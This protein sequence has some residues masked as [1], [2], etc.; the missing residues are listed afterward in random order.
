MVARS[1][2][3]VSPFTV[4]IHRFWV[5][6]GK[7]VPVPAPS[8][9]GQW[10]SVVPDT[11][12]GLSPSLDDIIQTDPNDPNTVG[13]GDL[14]SDNFIDVH[15][16]E[17][18]AFSGNPARATPAVTSDSRLLLMPYGDGAVPVFDLSQQPRSHFA[19][20]RT[21]NLPGF[22]GGN[23]AVSPN[24]RT[25]A[26]IGRFGGPASLTLTA[27][28]GAHRPLHVPLPPS[29]FKEAPGKPGVAFNDRGSQLAIANENGSVTVVDPATGSILRQFDSPL[30]QFMPSPRILFLGT[31]NNGRLIEGSSEPHEFWSADLR[32]GMLVDTQVHAFGKAFVG[33]FTA[34]ATGTRLVVLT[35]PSGPG[36]ETV[37]VFNAS[38]T[39]W[40]E[41]TS[42]ALPANDQDGTATLSP[43]GAELLVG[44]FAGLAAY[45]TDDG[46]RLWR[47]TSVGSANQWF[48]PDGSLLTESATTG[49]ISVRSPSDGTVQYTLQSLYPTSVV[50][51]FNV[52]SYSLA[53]LNGHV[54]AAAEDPDAGAYVDLVF[55]ADYPTTTADLVHAACAEA[56]RNLTHAEWALYVGPE[57]YELTCPGLPPPD[58]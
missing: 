31:L 45:R 10:G 54:L 7:E 34:D 33:D 51:T 1:P 12:I 8:D 48:G 46:A 3:S 39:G 56:G 41:H 15:A 44:D 26:S 9:P 24:G 29:P 23:F 57:P 25:L 52:P 16:A 4:P 47:D 20:I 42:F 19:P 22:N 6:T 50:S 30:H 18:P 13:I 28:D 38:G 37:H 43:G 55:V 5:R 35:S 14:R 27:L 11:P 36:V 58:H 53:F 17:S 32:S 2:R 21:V 49:E 40:T